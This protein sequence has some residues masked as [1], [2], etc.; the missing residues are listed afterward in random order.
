MTIL[1]YFNIFLTV[2]DLDQAI[3]LAND[4]PFGLGASAWTNDPVE[5]QRLINAIEAGAVDHI[6]F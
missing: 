2:K 4:I 3:A 6:Y 5:Q 1:S